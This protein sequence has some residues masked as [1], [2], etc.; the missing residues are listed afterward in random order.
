[1][2][3]TVKFDEDAAKEFAKLDRETQRKI[4]RYIVQRIEPADDPRVFAKPLRYEQYGFWR[5]RIGDIRLICQI[6]DERL[7]VLILRVGHRREIYE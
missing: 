4:Q 7:V 5:F 3:W 2:A 1:M 6:L